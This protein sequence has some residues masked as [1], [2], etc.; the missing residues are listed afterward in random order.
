MRT[1]VC[2]LIERRLRSGVVVIEVL[3][4]VIIIVARIEGIVKFEGDFDEGRSGGNDGDIWS[5][6]GEKRFDVEWLV[7][8]IL[9][10][11]RRL[12]GRL[13]LECRRS[14]NKYGASIDRVL[15]SCTCPDL[16]LLGR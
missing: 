13:L 8:C 3:A 16:N 5:W 12:G 9:L 11:E 6:G 2:R 7:L 15:K 10:K 4:V 14:W 1:I